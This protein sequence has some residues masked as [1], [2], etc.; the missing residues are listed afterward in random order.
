MKI[1]KDVD[2]KLKL[3]KWANP[4]GFLISAI[5]CYQ[6]VIHGIPWLGWIVLLIVLC[7]LLIMTPEKK[8][9]LILTLVVAIT[10]F[11]LD[12][13]LII[14]KVYSVNIYSRWILPE[15]FCPDW[16]LALWM[17][18]GFMMYIN[19]RMMKNRHILA[20]IIGIVFA[21]IIYGNAASANLIMLKLPNFTS[22]IIIAAIWAILVPAIY[23]LARWIGEN[24]RFE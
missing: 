17:N 21:F 1:K 18:F 7:I 14:F 13:C 8:R 24:P 23:R 5:S 9:R 2:V 19:W 4:V 3:F 12:S 22:L 20:A 6:G 10:G 16:I 15:P 11:A